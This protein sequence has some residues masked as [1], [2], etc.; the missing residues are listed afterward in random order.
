MGISLMEGQLA[1]SD[2][3]LPLPQCVSSHILYVG[4]SIMTV[5]VYNCAYHWLLSTVRT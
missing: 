3:I 2:F 1:V 5:T 4:M